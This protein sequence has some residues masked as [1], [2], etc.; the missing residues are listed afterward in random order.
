MIT[1]RIAVR[2]GALSALA[3]SL[4]AVM[5]PHATADCGGWAA[6]GGW[7]SCAEPGVF[8][9]GATSNGTTLTAFA[10]PGHACASGGYVSIV[11]AEAWPSGTKVT[12]T[13]SGSDAQTAQASSP[14]AIQ[15]HKCCSD[16][17]PC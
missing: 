2:I 5:I 17:I 13:R 11:E 14:S 4:G 10:P 16:W 7:A 9:G 15:F 8:T 1:R 6:T 3:M 12:V